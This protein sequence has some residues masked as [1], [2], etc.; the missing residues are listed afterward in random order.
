MDAKYGRTREIFDRFPLYVL[1]YSC[2][3]IVIQ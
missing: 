2:F 1:D 3:I